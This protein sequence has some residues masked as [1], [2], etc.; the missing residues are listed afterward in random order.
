MIKRMFTLFLLTSFLLTSCS[1]GATVTPASAEFTE[2]PM[3]DFGPE[4]YTDPSQPV[5]ARI[6]DLLKRMTIDE[7]IGQ[8]TQPEKGS[9]RPGDVAALALGSVISGGGG[10]PTPNTPADMITNAACRPKNSTMGPLIR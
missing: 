9:V 6:E 1:S 4:I 10:N 7:K 5:E 2:T 3:Q 8:M